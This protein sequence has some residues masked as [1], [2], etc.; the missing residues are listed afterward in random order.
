MYMWSI[1]DTHV[2]KN[3]KKKIVVHNSLGHAN[4]LQIEPTLT[5]TQHTVFYDTK[6]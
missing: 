3:K 6:M 2:D 5:V 1:R 4:T